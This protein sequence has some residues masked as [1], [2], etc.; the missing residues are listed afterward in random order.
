MTADIKKL[1]DSLRR[2]TP[3]KTLERD[4]QRRRSELMAD[5]KNGRPFQLRDSQGRILRISR[6]DANRAEKSSD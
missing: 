4:I 5:L 1:S 2:D 6:R 3:E